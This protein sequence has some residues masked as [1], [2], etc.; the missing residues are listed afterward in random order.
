MKIFIIKNIIIFN[1]LVLNA[2]ADKLIV[3]NDK[4]AMI[5]ATRVEKVIHLSKESDIN[6]N[7]V[8]MDTGGSTDVSPT[9]NI[10]FT[11]YKRGEMFSTDASFKLGSF[12]SLNSTRKV[13]NGLYSLVVESYDA[14]YRM[15]TMN[16][17]IDAKKAMRALQKVECGDEFDCSASTQFKSSISF[18]RKNENDLLYIKKKTTN[19]ETYHARI[20]KRVKSL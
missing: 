9:K 18:Y 12:F 4:D 13:S 14:N 15:V 17:I 10:Y 1:I 6:V 5:H 2:W 20:N 3:S 19:I 11:L 8:L 16:Y 7:I